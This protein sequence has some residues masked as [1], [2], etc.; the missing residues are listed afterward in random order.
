VKYGYFDDENREYFIDAAGHLGNKEDVEKYNS[1][2]EKVKISSEEMLWDGEWYLRGFT[3][4]G[5][6]IGS[7][8]S[9]EGKL[10]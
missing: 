10:F 4:S 8:E 7:R 1:I 3:K 5:R 2:A 9:E 6:E